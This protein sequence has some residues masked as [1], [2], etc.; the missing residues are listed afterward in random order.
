MTTGKTEEDLI[1]ML[2]EGL[3]LARIVD[4]NVGPMRQGDNGDW[5]VDLRTVSGRPPSNDELMTFITMKLRLRREYHLMKV[6]P[7]FWRAHWPTKKPLRRS[8]PLVGA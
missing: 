4:A 5:D 3:G 7:S 8:D 6:L 2:Y 1:G